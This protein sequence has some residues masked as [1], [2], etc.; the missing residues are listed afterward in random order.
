[1]L[2]AQPLTKSKKCGPGLADMLLVDLQQRGHT[3]EEDMTRP[4]PKPSQSLMPLPSIWRSGKV[5]PVTPGT[6]GIASVEL[7]F[8]IPYSVDKALTSGSNM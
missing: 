3:S 7:Q 2:I 4:F 6:L 1:M 5:H 8:L